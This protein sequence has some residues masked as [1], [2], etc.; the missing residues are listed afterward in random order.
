VTAVATIKR[1]PLA[2]DV[3]VV[4]VKRDDPHLIRRYATFA[5]IPTSRFAHRFGDFASEAAALHRHQ[6]LVRKLGTK[7]I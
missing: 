2:N 6:E 5:V 4:T 7:A 1:T 3:V